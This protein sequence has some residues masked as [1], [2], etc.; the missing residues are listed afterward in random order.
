MLQLFFWVRFVLSGLLLMTCVMSLSQPPICLLLFVSSILW[1][2]I[3]ISPPLRTW[4]LLYVLQAI[5]QFSY[6]SLLSSAPDDRSRTL[7]LA[8]SVPH[9]G[10][11]LK[12]SPLMCYIFSSLIW[13]SGS[14]FSIG[15]VYQWPFLLMIAQSVRGYVIYGRPCSGLWRK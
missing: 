5:D 2:V 7:A 10:D 11:C 8:S 3:L 14:A 6:Q 15:L 9:S 4:I 12:F 13:S 1:W